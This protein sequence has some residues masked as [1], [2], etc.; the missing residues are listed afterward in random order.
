MSSGHRRILTFSGSTSAA[1]RRPR[2]WRPASTAWSPC[3]PA[4][5]ESS[6]ED[7]DRVP[8]ALTLSATD[9]ANPFGAALACG[10]LF[11]FVKGVAL[12]I[13]AISGALTVGEEFGTMSRASVWRP[14]TFDWHQPQT[15]AG[16]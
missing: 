2:T 15:A 4:D 7:P 1:S 13:S 16:M 11:G 9:P 10:P 6:A 3:C 5:A 8:R 12:D 14:Y